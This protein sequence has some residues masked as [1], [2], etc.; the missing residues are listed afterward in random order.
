MWMCE[1]GV[2]LCDVIL[3]EVWVV[4]GL[5]FFEVKIIGCL[6]VDWC[7]VVEVIVWCF[8]I[9]VLWWDLFEWFGNWNMIYKNFNWWAV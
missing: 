8:C 6:F 5:L 7:V 9:G 3:D 2:M 4:I 1:F